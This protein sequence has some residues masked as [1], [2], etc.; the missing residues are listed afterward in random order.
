[1][2]THK[3]KGIKTILSV[4][5]LLFVSYG[6]YSLFSSKLTEKTEIL[7]EKKILL[8][9][10][11]E[12]S[13][14]YDTA[15]KES[16]EKDIVLEKAKLKIDHLIDSLQTSNTTVTDLLLLKEKQLE[17]TS[18]MKNLIR[19]NKELIQDNKIL[20]HSLQKRKKQ[21]FESQAIANALKKEN[22]ELDA[23]KILL[24]NSIEEAKYLTLLDLEIEGIKERS[25]G[26]EM[27]TNKAKRINKLKICY[28][29]AKNNLVQEG[30]KTMQVQILDPNNE[31][32]TQNT[33]A[34]KIAESDILY[35]FNTT[36]S[37]KNENL[38]V[39]DYFVFNA[40]T[41]LEKGTYQIHIYDNKNVVTSATITLK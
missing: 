16:E 15:I 12:T 41:T 35:S 27:I 40:D 18:E 24:N 28:A 25:S 10:L 26:K 9:Q 13:L 19:D 6:A 14:A 29:I 32:V 34:L 21:L 31:L 3:K 38:N 20:V 1:M 30:D 11:K 33:G 5:I 17:I 39:C 37:Y 8:N 2:T 7:S 23:E 22:G 4:I 36:F